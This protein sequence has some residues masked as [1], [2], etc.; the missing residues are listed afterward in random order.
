MD[1]Q[2]EGLQHGTTSAPTRALIIQWCR[3]AMNDLTA[4]MV[5]NAWRH[6]EYSW[7]PLPTPTAGDNDDTESDG[8]SVNNVADNADK[9]DDDDEELE[10]SSSVYFSA[11]SSVNE[12]VDMLPSTRNKKEEEDNESSDSD[13][14]SVPPLPSTN[15]SVAA[16]ESNASNQETGNE[17]SQLTTLSV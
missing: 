10:E 14:E 6:A 1:D 9:L 15:Y 12:A 13:D 11:N 5:R 7:F 3:F 2:Y 17:D 16:L 8:E 4:Q